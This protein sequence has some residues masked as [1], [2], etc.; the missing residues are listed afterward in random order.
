M[1][2]KEIVCRLAA[3]ALTVAITAGVPGARAATP[4]PPVPASLKNPDSPPI[5]NV[6]LPNGSKP[7]DE[8]IT[9]LDPLFQTEPSGDSRTTLACT[10]DSPETGRKA[11]YNI[12]VEPPNSETPCSV[13]RISDWIPTTSNNPTGT[14]IA[15]DLVGLS[16]TQAIVGIKESD[17]IIGKIALAIIN[18]N[19]SISPTSTIV[20]ST[21]NDQLVVDPVQ[22]D[23]EITGSLIFD[24]PR[25]ADDFICTPISQNEAVLN[26]QA[27]SSG[28]SEITFN[29]PKVAFID[30]P[31]QLSATIVSG[32]DHSV[33]CT[34]ILGGD[35]SLASWI[36][37]VSDKPQRFFQPNPFTVCTVAKTNDNTPTR[38]IQAMTFDS[39]G[40]FDLRLT[41]NG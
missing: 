26:C 11:F 6:L 30:T 17:A 15:V 23:G 25:T 2:R 36:P 14:T 10:I 40:R 39:A 24:S 4:Q 3:V 28:E 7:A 1:T 34:E 22:S 8:E 31:T 38:F 5:P 18:S 32:G 9:C 41:A 19:G 21:E 35:A 37:L 27:Y 12:C 13:Q 33:A 29:T 16:A 20:S